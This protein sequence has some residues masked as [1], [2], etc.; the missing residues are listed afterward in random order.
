MSNGTL[1]EANTPDQSGPWNDYNRRVLCIPQSSSITGA[2]PL[3]F[4]MSY[5]GHLLGEYYPFAEMQLVY[6]T[7][8]PDW[9]AQYIYIYSHP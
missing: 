2:S 7:T 4:C 5:P 3:D 9:A 6:S 8:P 1:S